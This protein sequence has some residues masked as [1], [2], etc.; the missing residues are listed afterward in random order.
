MLVSP[1]RTV[2]LGSFQPETIEEDH[3]DHLEPEETKTSAKVDKKADNLAARNEAASKTFAAYA[4]V[5]SI[6]RTPQKG[7]NALN[8][9]RL[10][11]RRSSQKTPVKDVRVYNALLK[12]FASKGDLAKLRE[13]LK[14]ADE[15][16]VAL[17]VQSYVAIFECLA[18]TNLDENNTQLLRLYVRNAKKQGITFDRIMNEGLFATDQRETVLRA[19]RMFQK[20][21]EPKYEL[22]PLHYSNHLLNHLNCEE[23][24]ALNASQTKSCGIFSGVEWNELIN[25]QLKV[26]SEGFLKVC[27]RYFA[28]F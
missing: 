20:D 21:Y 5:C 28:G 3:S 8:F 10:R 18:R 27:A 26:E 1:F 13:V 15:E 25:K 2:K 23:Q 14:Y 6:L 4:E 9:H 12:G 11:V 17:D 16:G 24:L 22:P 19:M 7:I